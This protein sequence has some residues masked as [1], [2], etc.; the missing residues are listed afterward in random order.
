MN[1]STFVH[2]VVRPGLRFMAGTLGNPRMDTPEAELLLLAIALQESGARHRAQI[3]GPA[4]GYWQFERGGGFAGILAHARTGPLI[5]TLIDELNLSADADELWQALPQSE[6][7]QTCFARML[8]WS[9]NAP[10]PAV[11]DKDAAW[12]VYLRNWRP[13]KPSRDRWDASYQGALD[14]VK[15]AGTPT[16]PSDSAVPDL[17]DQLERTLRLLRSAVA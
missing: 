7:L 6:L 4:R 5:H 14:V 11:G 15:A 16:Q 8:L 1:P 13:G 2:C 3:K 12:A 10:L 17:L 9:D